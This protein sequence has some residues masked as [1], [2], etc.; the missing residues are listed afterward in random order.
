MD[1]RD[2]V[3]GLVWKELSIFLFF[4]VIIFSRVCSVVFSVLFIWG[5]DSSRVGRSGG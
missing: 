4:D 2:L 3:E 5:E 1:L